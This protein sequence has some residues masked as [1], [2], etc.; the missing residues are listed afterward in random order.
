MVAV[1]VVYI[2]IIICAALLLDHFLRHS[3]SCD[4]ALHR[5]YSTKTN[6][7]LAPHGDRWGMEKESSFLRKRTKK[8]H[9]H[10]PFP[11]LFSTLDLLFSTENDVLSLS[12]LPSST[13]RK[14]TRV[15][16][17]SMVVFNNDGP[18]DALL[19]LPPPPFAA[20]FLHSLVITAAFLLQSINISFRA[21]RTKEKLPSSS[22]RR[23][24]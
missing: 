11:Y 6:H 5:S 15:Q 10:A 22:R 23:L 9:H 17:T 16:Y 3:L 1:V 21:L 19:R 24:F 4:A 2:I 13:Q 14:R 8:D 20:V 12:I 7:H 18:K